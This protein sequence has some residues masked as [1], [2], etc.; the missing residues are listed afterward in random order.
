MCNLCVIYLS[1]S[2]AANS[3][4]LEGYWHE[5]LVTNKLSSFD[6]TA[7]SCPSEKNAP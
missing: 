2:E 3:C 5:Y 1:Y 6:E 7:S 4:L